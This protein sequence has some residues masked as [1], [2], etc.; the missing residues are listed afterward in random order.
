[1]KDKPD[2]ARRRF[3]IHE[4]DRMH[5]L[6]GLPLAT[7][8]QRLLGFLVDL[9]LALL[10]W[11]PLEYCWRRYLLHEINIA[12]AARVVGAYA[13]SSGVACAVFFHSVQ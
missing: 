1:M 13:G 10:L 11:I 9:F 7:G 8:R 2:S 5:A 6:E 3:H 12:F 4:T